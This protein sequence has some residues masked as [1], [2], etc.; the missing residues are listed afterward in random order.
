MGRT[1]GMMLLEGRRQKGIGERADYERH[2]GY[3]VSE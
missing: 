2:V 3:S 1:S